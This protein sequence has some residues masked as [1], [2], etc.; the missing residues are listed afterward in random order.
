M[1][2]EKQRWSQHVENG[3][4][5]INDGDQKI[6]KLNFDECEAL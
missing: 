2:G 4:K 1:I 3:S 5:A 6:T